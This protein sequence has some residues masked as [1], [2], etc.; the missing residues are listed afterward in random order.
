MG[1]C[2]FYDICPL[3]KNPNFCE[4]TENLLLCKTYNKLKKE[5]EIRKRAKQISNLKEGKRIRL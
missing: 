2:P 1:R 5:R 4:S 3:P